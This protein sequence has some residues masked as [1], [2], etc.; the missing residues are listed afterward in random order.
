MD[1]RRFRLLPCNAFAAETILCREDFS[2]YAPG[3]RLIKDVGWQ[4]SVSEID[5]V[6]L[7]A[8]R[9]DGEKD[10][11]LDGSTNVP[12]ERGASTVPYFSRKLDRPP[13]P[14]AGRYVV[15]EV[16]LH[17]GR[18]SPITWNSPEMHA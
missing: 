16:D 7:A 1:A 18:R 2:R 8:G 11:F 4:R 9:R 12:M 6:S 15:L 13:D 17:A 14:L 3:A 10:V 5:D